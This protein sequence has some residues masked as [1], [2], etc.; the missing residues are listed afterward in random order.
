M[1]VKDENKIKKSFTP[2]CIWVFCLLLLWYSLWIILQSFIST[3]E[4]L[5]LAGLSRKELSTVAV[6]IY[7]TGQ[8]LYPI[9][10][11]IFILFTI[12]WV[13][14]AFLLIWRWRRKP[15]DTKNLLIFSLVILIISALIGGYIT[16]LPLKEII[17]YIK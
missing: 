4:F 15:P 9:S 8:F 14:I 16:N 7:M 13:V 6:F 1:M 10:R 11:I 17:T 5:N 12:F 2:I 3:Y